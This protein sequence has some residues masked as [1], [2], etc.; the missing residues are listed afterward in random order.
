MGSCSSL[1]II[2]FLVSG[3]LLAVFVFKT[4]TAMSWPVRYW[5]STSS[6]P[7]YFFIG[8]IHQNIAVSMIAG[9]QIEALMQ[10]SSNSPKTNKG[11]REQHHS[12]NPP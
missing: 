2:L 5:S 3:R 1:F 11:S 10:P 6:D 9:R 4:K 7:A 8:F 12:N